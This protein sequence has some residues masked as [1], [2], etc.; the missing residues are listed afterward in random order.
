MSAA[1]YVVDNRPGG[2]LLV[3]RLVTTEI[4]GTDSIAGAVVAYQLQVSPAPGSATFPDVPPSDFGFQY[5]EALVASGITGGCGGGLYCPNSP[6]TRR[7]MA[8]FIA[9]ALGL[10]FP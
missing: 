9:K 3:I 2:N 8:I 1:G 5:V 10:H 6:V 4:D 7:Q